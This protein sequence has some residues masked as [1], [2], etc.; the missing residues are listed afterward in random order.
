MNLKNFA[1]YKNIIIQCHDNPD[2]DA[3]GSGFALQ[4]FL[5]SLGCSPVMV[6]GGF[7][8]QKPS[9][10]MMLEALNIEIKH[11]SELPP[12]TDLLITVDC[13]RG[14]GNVTNFEL[15]ESAAV[16]I[17]DHHKPEI[18]ENES[19]VIRPDLASCATLMWSLLQEEKFPMD[20]RVQ[21][22]LYYG[23]FTDTNG[24]SE[25]RHP[26]DRDLADI[27]SDGGLIRKLK[28]SAITAEELDIIGETLRGRDRIDNIG[29]FR[30]EPCDAN[31]L[32]FTSDIAQQVVNMDCCVVYCLKTHEIKL[33]IRSSAREI[34]ANEIANFLC[35][36]TGSG[37]GAQDKAGGYLSLK[38]IAQVSQGQDP[39]D[40]LKSRIRSYLEH[41]DLIYAGNNDIDFKAMQLYKKL[42]SP[43]GFV[44]STD[45]FKAGTKIT[46]RTLEGDVDNVAGDDIYLMIGIIGEVYPIKKEQFEASYNVLDAPYSL[47]LEY[48][49]AVLNRITGERK[50]ILPFAKTCIPNDYKLVRAKALEKDTKVF[51]QWDTDKYFCGVA[52]DWLMANEGRYEDCYIVRSDI[53]AES[54]GKA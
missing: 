6:Y 52:G 27:P 53:F 22:S 31:L 15:P 18:P 19:T 28:N 10:L 38:G 26:L 45:I 14:A 36:E 9:L 44:P 21:N 40:Y 1:Q 41:Y 23:L 54:Y 33:S 13:Q 29:L 11:V 12:D 20:S 49:P 35:H 2:A 34:M 7:K 4:C 48:T 5:R 16:V 3:V 8:I 50:I 37:G 25:L 46:I 42:Q 51:T 43:V 32:G 24:L 39:V 17:I 30:A 47:Q